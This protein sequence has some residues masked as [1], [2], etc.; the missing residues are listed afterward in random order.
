[1]SSK[2][3]SIANNGFEDG[4]RRNSYHFRIQ[5]FALAAH[6]ISAC[7]LHLLPKNNSCRLLG[8]TSPNC[9]ICPLGLMLKILKVKRINA[10]GNFHVKVSPFDWEID[11][12]DE[13]LF[14]QLTLP[15]TI[16]YHNHR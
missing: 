10:G 6:D 14:H 3:I 2:T 11:I 7:R 5:S 4:D 16:Y 1:M 12:N 13:C 8:N 15:H 9:T